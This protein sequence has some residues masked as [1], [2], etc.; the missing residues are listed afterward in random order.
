[1]TIGE[2]VD[3]ILENQARQDVKLDAITNIQAEHHSTL[4][5]NGKPGLRLDV[6][7]LKVF[8]RTACWFIGSCVV[9]C[10]GLVGKLIYAAVTG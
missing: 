8:K 9:T 2:K 5:G 3:K 4:Y 10:I 6:D 7:R 1:M